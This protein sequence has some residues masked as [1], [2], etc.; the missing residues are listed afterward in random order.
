MRLTKKKAL[1]IAIELWEWIVDNPGKEK[2]EWPEWK[3]YGNMVF[4]CPFCQYGMSAY[5]ENCNCP[6]SK[7]YGDCDDSAY[8]S[9]DYDD[10]DGGHAAAVEF[11]AQLKELK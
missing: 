7:E 9:W 3:K 6:L 4:Y 5:H 11:L 1:E 2:R 8:G 10:E